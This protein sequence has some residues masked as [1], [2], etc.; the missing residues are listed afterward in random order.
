MLQ[1][2]N[3]ALGP[4]EGGI[5]RCEHN[6]VNVE[7]VDGVI[8]VQIDEQGHVR[9]GLNKAKGLRWIAIGWYIDDSL[10]E[11]DKARVSTTKGSGRTRRWYTRADQRS[12]M[13]VAREVGLHMAHSEATG[14]HMAQAEATGPAWCR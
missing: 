2:S 1:G 6:V 12:E 5:G 7:E 14:P 4:K 10:R 3:H 9:P 11:Q 8:V 13:K